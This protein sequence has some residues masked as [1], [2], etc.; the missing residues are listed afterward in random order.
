[1][2]H[3]GPQ[4]DNLGD[5]WEIEDVKEQCQTLERKLGAI[6]GN[7]VFRAAAKEYAQHWR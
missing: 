2:Y 5:I 7:D 4:S 6:E 1:M 3:V